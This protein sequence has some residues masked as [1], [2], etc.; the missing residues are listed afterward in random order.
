M[1]GP[2]GG[3]SAAL[4]RLDIPCLSCRTEFLFGKLRL[5]ENGHYSGETLRDGL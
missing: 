5:N 2:H 3:I 1:F 4:D